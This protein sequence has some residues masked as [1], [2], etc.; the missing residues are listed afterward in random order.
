MR[1][2]AKSFLSDIKGCR[3][4]P[5]VPINVVLM[6]GEVGSSRNQAC[7]MKRDR[8]LSM[9][10]SGSD[11]HLRRIDSGRIILTNRRPFENSQ[12]GQNEQ[13]RQR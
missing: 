7:F 4:P 13:T 1:K 10:V 6:E 3:K 2:E 5:I 11:Q 8:I 9:V 12:E